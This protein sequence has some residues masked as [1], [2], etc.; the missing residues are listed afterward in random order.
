MMPD[1]TPRQNEA[2]TATKQPGAGS[3]SKDKPRT[4]KDD[5]KHIVETGLPPG[6]EVE[7][8]VDPGSNVRGKQTGDRS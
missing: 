3:K 5:L 1:K 8:A 2:R 7:D 4:P 6:I